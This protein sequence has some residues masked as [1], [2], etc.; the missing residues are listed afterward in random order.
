MDVRNNFILLMIICSC[1]KVNELVN[2]AQG[3]ILEKQIEIARGML[4]CKLNQLKQARDVVKILESDFEE[5]KNMNVEDIDV[6]EC[7]RYD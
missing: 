4:E 3:C 7:G 1:M 2:D 5:L 6:C